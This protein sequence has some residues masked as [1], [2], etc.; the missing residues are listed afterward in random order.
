MD[1]GCVGGFGNG[2]K[3]VGLGGKTC[4]GNGIR[5]APVEGVRIR[6]VKDS[7]GLKESTG[8]WLSFSEA[9]AVGAGFH[10]ELGRKARVAL[11]GDI[12][13]VNRTSAELSEEELAFLLMV[14][15]TSTSGLGERRLL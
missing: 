2:G 8:P 13:S 15:E 3:K 11:G 10:E 12:R 6:A 4:T 7:S 9:V 5:A 1:R 14:T